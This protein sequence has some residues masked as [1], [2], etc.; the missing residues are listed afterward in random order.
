LNR[1]RQQG[2]HRVVAIARVRES[3]Y[4]ACAAGLHRGAGTGAIIRALALE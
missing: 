3:S 1:P 4:M 2:G